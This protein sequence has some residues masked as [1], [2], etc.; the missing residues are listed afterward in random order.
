MCREKAGG[1][2]G[3]VRTE[4]GSDRRGSMYDG[5]VLMGHGVSGVQ[6]EKARGK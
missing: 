4:E 5:D 3:G 6:G 2:Q 1:C